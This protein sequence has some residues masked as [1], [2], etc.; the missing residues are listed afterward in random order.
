MR[1][2]YRWALVALD[3]VIIA[4]AA[5]AAVS[6]RTQM[7]FLPSADDAPDL[8]LPITPFIVVGWLLALAVG[9]S[10]RARHWGV[11]VQ[12]YR[13]V[14]S[15]SLL[16]VLALGFTSFVFAYP[17]SRGFVVILLAIGVPA[18]ILERLLTRRL[19]Q[20]VRSRGRFCVPTLVIGDPGPVNDVVTVLR[21]EAWL[22][23]APVGIITADDDQDG[24]PTGHPVVGSVDELLPVIDRTGARAVIFT[25]GSVQR[26]HEFNEIARKLE[27]HDAEMIVVPAMTDISGQRLQMT[28]V[29]G[30]PLMHVGKPQAERSLRFT[31]RAFDLLVAAALVVLLSP[32]MLV[33]A[34]LIKL[35]DGGPILFKQRRVGRAGET[36]DLFKFRSMVPDAERIR[37]EQ[38]E[39]ANESDGALFKIKRDPR[40]TRVGRVIRRF[41]I[42]ELPQLFN[43]LRGEMSL[44]GPRP[45]LE[46]E[47]ALYETHVR[48]RLDVRP[49]MTGL[50]QVSGRSDLDWTDTV[51]LDLYYVDN[52]SMVQDLVILLRTFNAVVSSRGAY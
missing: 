44:I 32:L 2:S 4:I 36:F 35:G 51:R 13:Q 43:V 23:Y 29:A 20:R 9:G 26:G 14:L 52:W 3:T 49:G 34:L 31:K 42:D 30:L 6:L 12:E 37:A 17:L 22:G 18:L 40:I 39:Q 25:T 41:S 7:P 15:A 16:F 46:R 19:L 11:G 47:V 1:S 27:R 21:R 5:F 24:P 28:P 50:W 10:Y 38:L 8:V 45:A 48:R 33:T